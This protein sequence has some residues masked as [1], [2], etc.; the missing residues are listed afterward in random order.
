V[1]S[2]PGEKPPG[3]EVLS[4]EKAVREAELAKERATRIRVFF[5][6]CFITLELL[7][8]KKNKKKSS[9]CSGVDCLLLYTVRRKEKEFTREPAFRFLFRVFRSKGFKRKLKVFGS[10]IQMASRI[11]STLNLHLFS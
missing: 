4:K 6:W 10:G 7:S 2:I 11:S 1:P 5:F 9:C 3:T 8:T